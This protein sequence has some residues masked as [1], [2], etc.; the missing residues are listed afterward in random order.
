MKDPH[1]RSRVPARQLITALAAT[2]LACAPSGAS[3]QVPA[4]S[5]RAELARLAARVDSLSRELA[6][7]RAQGEPAPAQEDALARLRAAAD[8]AAGRGGADAPATPPEQQEFVG[9]QRSLQA[10]N[11]EVSVTGDIIAQPYQSNIDEP[12][13]FPREFELSFVSNLDPFSRARVFASHH[14]PGAE[15]IPFGEEGEEHEEGMGGPRS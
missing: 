10:L 8:S 12:H 5:V 7:M 13:F 9:R 6:R 1:T 3:A 2:V 11:P 14:S 4:D 15:I